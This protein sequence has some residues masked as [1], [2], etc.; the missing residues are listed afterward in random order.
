MA[1]SP[2]FSVIVTNYNNARY[3]REA[4]Y[5]VS[6]Q[7]LQDYELIV[8]ENGSTDNSREI[9]EALRPCFGDKIR[10]AHLF[11]NQGPS[12]ARNTGIAMARGSYLAFLDSDDFWHPERL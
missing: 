3:M 12:R 10:C 1:V 11:P 4:L 8:V 2:Q 6:A 7:T 9:I 5:S